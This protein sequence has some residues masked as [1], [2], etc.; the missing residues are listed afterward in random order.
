MSEHNEPRAEVRAPPGSSPS[1][2][3]E[4]FFRHETGRLHGALTRLLG[5]GNLTLV[6]DVAH[7]R[8][9][10]IGS[11]GR[12]RLDRLR[13][14]AGFQV[15]IDGRFWVSTEVADR[16]E[17]AMSEQLEERP[18]NRRH[19]TRRRSDVRASEVLESI[20]DGIY[21]LDREWRFTYMNERGLRSLQR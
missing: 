5:P 15:S 2:I 7:D 10:A 4:H 1:Q 21:A 13:V 20:T 18:V 8:D 11:G 17:F 12:Q 19:F 9:G 16:L 6:E 3:V 14:V